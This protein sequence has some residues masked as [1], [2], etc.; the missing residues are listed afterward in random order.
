MR[1][2]PDA[3]TATWGGG[4]G[5]GDWQHLSPEVVQP[6]E[7]ESAEATHTAVCGEALQ[8]HPHRPVPAQ[9]LSASIV[10]TKEPLIECTIGRMAAWCPRSTLDYPLDRSRGS[11]RDALP[12]IPLSQLIRGSLIL[13]GPQSPVKRTP[14]QEYSRS[15]LRGRRS[16]RRTSACGGQ[17]KARA[18]SHEA[19]ELFHFCSKIIGPDCP[20]AET[21]HSATCS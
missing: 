4:G 15:V 12:C 8:H 14:T 10:S 5:I 6:D 20:N 2:C 18:L 3:H 16:R 1:L 13:H 9:A 21:H 11:L 17:R 7:Q 19:P